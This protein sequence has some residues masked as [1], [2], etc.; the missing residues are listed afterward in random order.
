MRELFNVEKTSKK[1]PHAIAKKK[2][3]S[4]NYFTTYPY[5]Y[6]TFND[7]FRSSRGAIT[8]YDLLEE[9]TGRQ[10]HS[11]KVSEKKL[12]HMK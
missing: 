6:N 3:H 11:Q 4:C 7:N 2:K 10:Q 1:N 8:M 9:P 5:S 12:R